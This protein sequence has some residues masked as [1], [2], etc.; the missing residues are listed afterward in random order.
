MPGI[1]TKQ[2]SRAA[3]S[4][5]KSPVGRS[6]R[7][8][9]AGVCLLAL[10]GGSYYFWRQNSPPEPPIIK[11]PDSD[12]AIVKAIEEG[13]VA[14]Q[15][16]PR[17]GQAW[18]RLGMVLSIH[19]VLPEADICFAQAE[20]FEP[21]EPRWPYLRGLARSGEDPAAALPSLQRAAE[22]CGDIPAPHLR[23]AE[24]LIERGR[25]EEAEAEISP[26]LQRDPR[27]ARALLCRARLAMA[28]GQPQKAL[29]FARQS[30]Q[31]APDVKASH[32][33]LGAIEQRSGNQAVRRKRSAAPRSC[34]RT[35][36]GPT[37]I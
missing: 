34:R 35:M 4:Q 14:V 37:H 10:A 32:T 17:S 19:D 25:L 13:R 1:R 3:G 22:G 21:R 30:I 11:L 29:E 23:L 2:K 18:G 20:R 16:A 33:L 6:I 8:F 28:R 27:D 24:L 12:P 9:F 36:C 15:R 7:R 26:V 5:K 31:H